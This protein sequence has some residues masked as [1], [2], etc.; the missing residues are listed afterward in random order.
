MLKS[1]GLRA[2]IVGGAGLFLL[3]CSEPPV[4]SKGRPFAMYFVPSVD[5]EQVNTGASQLT[6]FVEKHVSQ[7]LY[8]ADKG[9]FVT[10]AVPTSYIAVVEAF[11]TSRA[12]FAALNTFSYILARDIKKYPIESIV[13]IVRGNGETTYKGQIIA[14][15]DS[16]VKSIE[17]LKGRS[18]AYTDPASTAGYILPSFLFKQKGIE[19]KNTMFAGKHDAVVMKVYQKE[20]DAGASYYSPPMEKEVDGKKVM[21]IRD[22]RL[23]V[24]TQYPDVEEKVRIIGFTQEIPNEPW[25]I[26]SNLYKDA[27]QNQKVKDAVKEAILAFMETP[28]GKKAIKDIYSVEGLVAVNDEAYNELRKII[29]AS[30]LDLEAELKK[31]K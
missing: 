12:D 23:R 27:S 17:D 8:G 16:G 21:E 26:R 5:A 13:Q 7:K 19:L 11:G 6:K 18:F 25:V 9:F 22:A 30:N 20:V 1:R 4:G 28:E 31:S 15:K 10:S 3:A 14:H 24:K 2:L 29:S